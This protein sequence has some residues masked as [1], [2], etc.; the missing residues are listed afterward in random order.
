RYFKQ[1][2]AVEIAARDTLV[3]GYI[4]LKLGT[5]AAD[6]GAGGGVPLDDEEDLDAAAGEM[7]LDKALEI[8]Q[9]NERGRQG[10]QRALLLKELREEEK[11][12]RIYDAT[13]QL[14]MDPEIAAANI[15]RL[16]RGSAARR[17]ARQERE[18]EMIYIG[19][20]P[21]ESAIGELQRELD[22]AYR[23]RKQEQAQQTD[24]RDAYE[25]A[26]ED[27]KD[28]VLEEEGPEMR[29][30]LREERTLWVTDQIAQ[31]KFPEDLEA[32]Y[33][34]KNPPAEEK[35]PAEEEGGGKKGGK[36]SVAT[37]VQGKAEGTKSSGYRLVC[38]LRADLPPPLQG[39]SELAGKIFAEVKHFSGV[40]EDRDE[41]DNFAQK[42]DVSLA[43]D[44]I[45]PSV[46][47]EIRSQVDEML[48]MNLQKIKM[49][50]AP[51]DSTSYARRKINIF[52]TGMWTRTE[53][54]GLPG[55][56]IAELKN[57]DTDQMISLLVENRLISTVAPR[58]VSDF[59]GDFN[60]LGM[61]HQHTER[62]E[63]QWVPQDPSMAQLRQLV[64]EFCILPVG[65]KQLK[66]SLKPEHNLK[67]VML[68]GPGG[69]GKTM[70][71]EAIA[72]EVTKR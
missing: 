47:E 69:A 58:R 65:S 29:E 16:F 36:V 54:K 9:R 39:K 19:M 32:F 10:K 61:I 60:Y 24:N 8:I 53:T 48:L 31:D 50:D 72:S 43:K 46:A 35:P 51:Y 11:K 17:R 49:Q 62:R 2:S 42:H 1:D 4:K 25:E 13:D 6:G 22:I 52:A 56:K 45:R 26:L 18:D 66:A 27:L 70:M 55:D 15:Q 30:S 23:K 33:L 5:G 34:L 12:R 40:W 7:T 14:E 3:K 64:T 63:G 20:K 28:V 71:V 68:Y 38:P 41:S 67:T 37:C 21:A 59:I 44:K 57:M